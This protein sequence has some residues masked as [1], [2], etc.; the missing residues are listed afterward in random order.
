MKPLTSYD[1]CGPDPNTMTRPEVDFL[2]VLVSTLPSNATIVTIG[3]ERGVSTLAILEAH[4]MA[5]VF[6]IDRSPCPTE[7]INL[8]M[9]NKEHARVVRLLGRSQEIGEKWPFT[10]S[11]VYVDGDHSKDGVEGDI[12]AWRAHIKV[13][14]IMAFH[15]YI[16]EPI[17]PHIK[18]RVVHAVDPL[19]DGYEEIGLVERLKAFRIE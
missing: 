8:A 3:A 9:A 18:G 17:P 1:L 10:V 11:M 19:M 13:G 2:K 12:Y 4:A 16:P 5:Y 14:G 15:D 6:S 7:F